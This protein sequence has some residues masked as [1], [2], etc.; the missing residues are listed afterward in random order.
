MF[1]Q[2]VGQVR[3]GI[4]TTMQST[5]ESQN[6]GDRITSVSM[7]PFMRSQ[8]SISVNV[9]NLKPNTRVYAFFDNENVSDFVRPA[10]IFKVNGSNIR[11]SPK[12]IQSPNENRKYRLR[13]FLG[14]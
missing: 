13:S 7:I 5:V 14:W 12:D 3:S 9:G 8:G 1:S 6:L 10:D 2:Q 11:F 4:R